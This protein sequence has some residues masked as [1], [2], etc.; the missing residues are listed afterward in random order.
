MFFRFCYDT[1]IYSGVLLLGL[2]FLLGGCAYSPQADRLLEQPLPSTHSAVELTEVPF[3]PQTQYQCGPA[4]L[5]TILNYRDQAVTPERL[6]SKVY[7][8]KR[9]GSFQL[10]MVAAARQYGQVAYVMEPSLKALLAEVEAGNP[11]LVLQNVGLDVYP[12][13]HFS[14]VV[15]YDLDAE[16]IVL[17][18]GTERRWQTSLRNFEQTWRKSGYWGLVIV[19]PETVPVSANLHDWIR[20]AYDLQKVGQFQAAESAFRSGVERWPER[21]SSWLA[22][23]NLLYLKQDHL[24]GIRLFQKM[25]QRF[26]SHAQM[27]NNYAYTLQAASCYPSAVRAARCAKKTGA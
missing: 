6:R 7:V 16:K 18:S 1:R 12:K 20:A 21:L 9:Q 26:S 25:Q 24:G 15:G 23:S 5:A 22:L 13:W 4:A 10:E 8:S 27:W 19:P 3:F 11:V 17:R 2:L 14:V